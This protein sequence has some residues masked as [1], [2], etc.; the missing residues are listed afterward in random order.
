MAL[1]SFLTPYK[2]RK[3]SVTFSEQARPQRQPNTCS[4]RSPKQQYC[5]TNLW[6]HIMLGLDQLGVL[7]VRQPETHT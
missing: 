2:A 4:Y 5:V 3:W 1:A 7:H 6:L